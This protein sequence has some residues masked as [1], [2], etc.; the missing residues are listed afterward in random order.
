MAFVLGYQKRRISKRAALIRQKYQK[1]GPDYNPNKPRLPWQ[2]ERIYIRN[3][4]KERSNKNKQNV[5]ELAGLGALGALG[6]YVGRNPFVRETARIGYSTLKNNLPIQTARSIVLS[7]LALAKEISSSADEIGRGLVKK[8]ARGVGQGIERGSYGVIGRLEN[9]VLT[10]VDKLG[11]ND[12]YI[13]RLLRLHETLGGPAEFRKNFTKQRFA[14]QA[15]IE[16]LTHQMPLNVQSTARR[17]IQGFSVTSPEVLQLGEAGPLGNLKAEL[18]GAGLRPT[19]RALRSQRARTMVASMS[20]SAA[21]QMTL[22][23]ERTF[24]KASDWRNAKKMFGKSAVRAAEIKKLQPTYKEIK[25]LQEFSRLFPEEFAALVNRFGLDPL[26][27][28]VT[29]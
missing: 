2:K 6:Y 27:G 10:Y 24:H 1:G 7:P 22:F 26:I 28:R 29:T 15:V 25:N 13:Q 3:A 14:R 11:I 4:I 9:A 21:K 16:Q 8:T 12:K 20:S 19:V 17:E 18:E 23:A 5:I